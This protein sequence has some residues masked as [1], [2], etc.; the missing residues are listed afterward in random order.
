MVCLLSPSPRAI[1]AVPV[2]IF[3]YKFNGTDDLYVISIVTQGHA[4][5]HAYAALT[6]GCD[7]HKTFFLLSDW[8]PP[9]RLARQRF[10]FRSPSTFAKR[11]STS[12]YETPFFVGL[13]A[14]GLVALGLVVCFFLVA[15]SIVY[16]ASSSYEMRCQ[17]R[18]TD[19]ES[20]FHMWRA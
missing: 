1:S 18:D 15:A 14:D 17:V 9:S 12:L 7:G 8:Y 6:V 10:S 5:G 13:S 19:I 2:Y 20:T 11:I 16:S 4:H 3:C